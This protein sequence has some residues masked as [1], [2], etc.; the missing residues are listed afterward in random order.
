MFHIHDK[1]IGKAVNLIDS[2]RLYKVE[3]LLVYYFWTAFSR[4]GRIPLKQ[5]KAK[6]NPYPGEIWNS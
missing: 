2:E 6:R 4:E 1:H 3:M 5:L